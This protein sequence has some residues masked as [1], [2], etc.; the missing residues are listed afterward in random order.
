MKRFFQILLL[1]IVLSSCAE[2]PNF[3]VVPEIEFLRMSKTEMVQG[4]FA[5]DSVVIEI[6]F[7]DGDGD[8]SQSSPLSGPN[9]FLIDSRTD[10]VYTT[11]RVP[12]I[13]EVGAN[14]GVEGVLFLRVYNTC[15]IFSQGIPPCEVFPSIPTNELTFDIYIVDNAGNKSNTVRTSAITLLCQ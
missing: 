13:P 14:N 7:K 2:S 8:L 12:E 4:R 10:Q 5:T 1:G 3:D 11:F 6:A 15:C 9:I